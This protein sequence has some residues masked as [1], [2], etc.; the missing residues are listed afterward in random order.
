MDDT[1]LDYSIDRLTNENWPTW[2]WQFTNVLKAKKLSKVLT[3]P[4]E[5]KGE[6]GARALA[7][8]GSSVS[9]EIRST[10]L[11][12]DDFTSAWKE[13]SSIFENK[14]A[15]EASSLFQK[16][17]CLKFEQVKDVIPG[18]STAMATRSQL[19]NVGEAISD[20]YIIGCVLNALPN[21]L[22]EFS[23]V[24]RN[25]NNSN[26]F[27]DLRKSLMA[28]VTT[29]LANNPSDTKAMNVRK[30]R[31]KGKK[32]DPVDKDSCRYCKEKGHWVKDCPKIK[33]KPRR[34]QEDKPTSNKKVAFAI[35]KSVL[36]DEWIADSGCTNHMTPFK[37]ILENYV[38]FSSPSTVG[39][40]DNG[41]TKL[42]IRGK[43]TINT[44]Q[45]ILK[46]VYYVP[47]LGQNLFSV[48]AA[49]RNGLSYSGSGDKMDFSHDGQ[50]VFSARLK[51]NL[52][53]INFSYEKQTLASANSA[54]IE[55]W[56]S[57]FGHISIDKIM[58]MNRNNVVEGLDFNSTSKHSCIDCGLGK[59]H[60]ST[61]GTRSTAKCS[62]PG[63]S[64][65]FDTIGPIT[66]ISLGG[67]SYFVLAKD[68]YSGYL[69]V[70][71]VNNKGQVKDEVK[72]MISR[73]QLETNN[74]VLKI[75]TD[76][77]SEFVNDNLRTFLNEKGII[78]HTSA[79][80]EPQQ[81][82]FI[83]REVRTVT[84][85]GRTMLIK[86]KLDKFLWAEAIVA[87]V[88]ILNR[89]AR[90]SVTQTAFELWFQKKPSVSNLRTF[91]QAAIIKKPDRK[92]DGKFDSKGTKARFIGYTDV[93]NTYRFLVNNK[94]IVITSDA[95]FLDGHD[96][97]PSDP[98]MP[99]HA[100]LHVSDS[101][102]LDD[103]HDTTHD[104]FDQS[105]VT[106]EQSIVSQQ[107][108]DDVFQS[109]NSSLN[110][111]VEVS[112]NT[113][114][115]SVDELIRD[116]VQTRSQ[117]RKEAQIKELEAKQANKP[118]ML[119]NEPIYDVPTQDKTLTPN[120]YDE[121]PIASGD[122]V[123][124]WE[125]TTRAKIPKFLTK[126]DTK[127]SKKD[128]SDSSDKAMSAVVEII[129]NSLAEICKME[130][131]K[132][133]LWLD[134]V[135]DELL[136]MESNGVYEI[137]DRP[138]TRKVLK[139]RWVFAIKNTAN[140]ILYKARWVA[141]G[142]SQQYGFD[143]EETYSP[144]VHIS[145]IRLLL[146][147]SIQA[148][149]SIC[150]FDIKTAFLN[151][152]LK[153]YIVIEPPEGC[154]YDPTKVW[155]LRKSLYGLKQ[156]SRCWNRKFDEVMK[157]IGLIK[158]K[159]DSCVYYS[160][161]T[162]LILTI[163][164]D[165]GLIFSQNESDA[166][167]LLTLL[168]LMFEMRRI[169]VS[170]YLGL[171]IKIDD[172]SITINQSEYIND[173]LE[174]FNMSSSKPVENPSPMVYDLR[175]DTVPENAPIREAIG[176]LMY[177]ANTSRPDLSFAVNY[178]ARNVNKPTLTLWKNIKRILRYLQGTKDL[179][180]VYRADN[181][182]LISF[183]DSDFA[184]DNDTRRS[185][186]GYLVIFSGGPIIW[187]TQRQKHVTLSS[188]EAEYV[189]LCSAA[190]EM[191]WLRRLAIELS[192]MKPDQPIVLRSDNTSALKIAQSEKVTQ[193]TRHL[194]AQEAYPRELI[195]KGELKIE[196]VRGTDQ[197]ADW[198]TKPLPSSKFLKNRNLMMIL[199]M[200][201]CLCTMGNAH[202]TQWTFTQGN[203]TEHRLVFHFMN[204]CPLITHNQLVSSWQTYP[205]ITWETECNKLYDKHWKGKIEKLL[206]CLPKNP[207]DKRSINSLALITAT[208]VS[209]L[210]T[211]EFLG[212]NNIGRQKAADQ[213]DSRFNIF[214]L[215][216][217]GARSLMKLFS[218]ST[219][220]H[221][222]LTEDEIKLF[223]KALWINMKV[224]GEIL[225]NSAN[226]QAIINKCYDRKLA[227]QELAEL[228][229]YQELYG[230]DPE[231]TYLISV[232][233]Q[234]HDASLEFRFRVNSHPNISITEDFDLS[235]G[236]YIWIIV[237]LISLSINI[238]ALI[239]YRTKKRP[240]VP[241]RTYSLQ[242][243]NEN[244]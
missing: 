26:S 220:K 171:N 241:P 105:L 182:N 9:D 195:E 67:N 21:A 191:S 66:P 219:E 16:M 89:I 170:K 196:Y 33:D 57:R 124:F 237:V 218:E 148:N 22:K 32:G 52:Y 225:A 55:E 142:Y 75:S 106:T 228:T 110:K 12:C 51:D 150:Q 156:S 185:T 205:S 221:L 224:H 172:S 42:S 198:L 213:F 44:R 243:I 94:N 155:R 70:S 96:E 158:S 47:D 83:E 230:I 40:C 130:G 56:H 162:L 123:P 92:I 180:I 98:K 39:L 13:I 69:M 153:E 188:T 190:K 222:L 114:E 17:N 167:E 35:H 28:E 93:S 101:L 132:R 206:D 151:G 72:K 27:E 187:K 80:Y 100:R 226:I 120:A 45:G 216:L 149:L 236:S 84:E 199:L 208:A 64:L 214:D 19:Q 3:D 189:A 82:G 135:S 127:G 6:N 178:V 102:D 111:E 113:T 223:S 77:G 192:I 146:A 229:N 25:S 131:H 34:H 36:I 244:Q 169:K 62:K 53:I 99:S 119:Q 116:F 154:N 239:L 117:A 175:E 231:Q 112:Q 71:I 68:E 126:K 43:G 193:R 14:T 91:G 115:Q 211:S 50:L 73:T 145:T 86:S 107:Q 179:S 152:E 1:K 97:S 207:R 186:T 138:K 232:E 137:I 160:E 227:T 233:S 240:Q 95:V 134:A 234:E 74:H 2:K 176:S 235:S 168:E 30:D 23:M 204:P 194:G 164:V 58:N 10:L 202:P 136:S 201:I 128:E 7:L 197:L 183:C 129:P 79:A 217:N 20:R 85:M 125:R 209:N 161:A 200:C 4:I 242:T 76:N 141:C 139:S 59:C 41:S 103:S 210:V 118:D 165:D 144:V 31:K 90:R 238:I 63:V 157:T 24:W 78:H 121:R 54:T 48:S 46:D 87:S 215:F 184:G 173:I 88:Y 60:R 109:A 81:N 104:S 38:E 133:K 5:A 174:R 29:Y 143:Y 18:L 181:Q 49:A 159:N 212:H 11:G 15:Y 61:H 177:L 163:Y 65:H 37:Q 166:R 140:G 108:V 203:A 8:L 122:H 147:F